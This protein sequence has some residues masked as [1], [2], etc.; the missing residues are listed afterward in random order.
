MAIEDRG[1]HLK[2]QEV[3][4]VNAWTQHFDKLGGACLPQKLTE[5]E[6][7]LITIRK[8][9]AAKNSG[10][11]CGGK[12]CVACIKFSL[13]RLISIKGGARHSQRVDAQTLSSHRMIRT[14]DF[15]AYKAL[16]Q[17]LIEY[18]FEKELYRGVAAGKDEEKK[19]KQ[20]A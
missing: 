13:A 20:V 12:E 19:C 16:G 4:P 11:D 7:S 15:N 8:T 2:I 6:L 3:A 5:Q 10:S 17:Q 18:L 14:K 9:I 1:L